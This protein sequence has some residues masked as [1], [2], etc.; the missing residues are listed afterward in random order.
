MYCCGAA[1]IGAIGSLRKH[2]V[3]VHN[4]P[5]LYCP[6]CHEIEVHPAVKE[7]FELVVQYA[8]E[9]GVKETTLRDKIDPELIAEWKEYCVSFQEADLEPILREQIDYSLDLLSATKQLGDAEW[10]E[11]L[12]NRLKVLTGRLKRLEEQKE[13]SK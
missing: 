8:V 11:E 1:M 12:K 9:D 7:E 3:F 6:V 2:S 13:S 4:V 10:G 5:L